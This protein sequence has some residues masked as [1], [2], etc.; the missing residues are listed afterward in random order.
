M[1]RGGVYCYVDLLCFLY[2]QFGMGWKIC[3]VLPAGPIPFVNSLCF[4]A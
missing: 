1:G 4:I 3:Y 2:T